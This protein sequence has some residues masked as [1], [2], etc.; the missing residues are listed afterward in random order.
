MCGSQL[1][2]FHASDRRVR[3]SRSPVSLPNTVRLPVW[4]EGRVEQVP[5]H[6]CS[7]LIHLGD[8]PNSGHYRAVLMGS[9]STY[10]ITD[11]DVVARRAIKSDLDIIL[12]NVCVVFLRPSS[13]VLAPAIPLV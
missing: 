5:F 4:V 6:F 9:D 10:W 2:R 13:H 12:R 7:A 3:K 11:D 8:T 1:S